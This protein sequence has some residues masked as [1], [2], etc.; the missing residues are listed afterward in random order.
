MHTVRLG[1]V[2]TQIIEADA[3]RTLC[4]NRVYAFLNT[5]NP[6]YFHPGTGSLSAIDL[7]LCQ[8]SLYLDLSWSVH[9]D[10]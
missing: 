2:E 7:S 3:W 1:A 5:G 10:L 8:P 9:K 6:T 4:S